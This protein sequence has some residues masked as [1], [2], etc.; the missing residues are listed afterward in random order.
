MFVFLTENVK[1]PSAP[2][3]ES[4]TK[5]KKRGCV[6]RC[7]Q[8]AGLIILLPILLY[9]G[10]TLLTEINPSFGLYIGQKTADLQYPLQRIVRLISLPLHDVLELSKLSA[11][12]C[13]VD[14]PLYV[15]G[16]MMLYW[17]YCYS[18]FIK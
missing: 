10:V 7:F 3:D 17:F 18:L 6:S 14:N 8:V 11:W 4:K 9:T 16:K 2:K 12:E 1:S 5:T 13:M 15:P